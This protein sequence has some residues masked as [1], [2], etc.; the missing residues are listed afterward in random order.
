MKLLGIVLFFGLS[1]HFI[2]CTPQQKLPNYLERVSDSTMRTDVQIPEL[3]IQKSD[4]LSIQVY[5]ASTKP[6]ISDAI[7]NLPAQSTGDGTSSSPG[8]LVDINGNIEYPRIGVIKAEGLTKLQLADT[9]KRKI[10]DNDS[11]LTNPSVIIRFQ[12]LKVTMLGELN[13]EGPI[14]VPAER[15][16]ILE[17]IGLAGGIK[18][19]GMKDSVK[20]IRELD[21]KRTAGWVDLTSNNLF[22]S[23]YYHLMQNDVVVVEPSKRKARK[24]EQEV[25]YRQAGFV[26]SLITAIAVVITVFQ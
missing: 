23:P 3:K 21:G 9:I 5:S 24:T 8:F 17:A 26:V 10:N 19:Y 2:S 20:V 22:E 1:V 25:F 14:S 12:N 4:L 6:E 16:T 13:R 7:F 11:V 15:V 18:E